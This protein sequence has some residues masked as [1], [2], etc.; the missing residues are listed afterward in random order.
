MHPVGITS[1]DVKIKR[2]KTRII[3]ISWLSGLRGPIHGLNLW[4]GFLYLHPPHSPGFAQNDNNDN[5]KKGVSVVCGFQG[6]KEAQRKCTSLL[7]L[8]DYQKPFTAC[9]DCTSPQSVSLKPHLDSL[10][11]LHFQCSIKPC[12]KQSPE[13]GPRGSN[14]NH[15]WVTR[16]IV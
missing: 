6:R 11:Y 12:K 5:G 1:A 14:T 15:P 16:L 10:F 7:T 2:P 8:R 13:W 3:V 4:L 9:V